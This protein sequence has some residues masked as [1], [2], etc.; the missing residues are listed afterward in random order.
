MSIAL[1]DC[2]MVY[3]FQCRSCKKSVES[4]RYSIP[5]QGEIV[6]PEL[7]C[8]WHVIDGAPYCGDHRIEVHTNVGIELGAFGRP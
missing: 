6:R 2:E 8:G 3:F 5:V 4:S 7:P 1:F